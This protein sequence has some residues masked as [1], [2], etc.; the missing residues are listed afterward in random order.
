MASNSNPWERLASYEE[1]IE[2][3]ESL[4]DDPM[5]D[6]HEV[7]YSEVEND[8]DNE[9]EKLLYNLEHGPRP[10]WPGKNTA[11]T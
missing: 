1:D 4:D 11:I 3:I 2:S 7:D 10:V 9:I 6:L 8:K 5:Q